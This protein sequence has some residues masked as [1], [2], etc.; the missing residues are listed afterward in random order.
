MIKR[1][2]EAAESQTTNH[3]TRVPKQFFVLAVGLIAGLFWVRLRA[4]LRRIVL[5]R[6][7]LFPRVIGE[8]TPQDLGMAYEEVWFPAR[9]GL[10]L[11]G[12]YIPALPEV[13]PKN[14]T[15]IMGHGHTGNKEPDL[16][17]A[18]FFCNAGYNVFMFDF[19]GHGRSEG[20]R[21][22]SMG[23][24]ERLDVHGAVDWLLGRGQERFAAFGIS[25]GASILVM[26]SA[27]NPY[28]KAVV[29]D[30][31]YAHLYRSIAAEINNMYRLPLWL[32]RPLAHYAWRILASHHS[33]PLDLASPADYVA[34]IAPR[35]L[36]IIH[37]EKDRL[38]RVE[39]A[40]ILYQLAGQPKELWIQ[41]EVAHAQGY[42]TYGP[43]YERRIL[44]F[45]EQ[46]D[47]DSAPDLHAPART[48]DGIAVSGNG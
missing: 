35:P 46:V 47:W 14:V 12:W 34:K 28:I 2:L 40:Y 31:A 41:P 26:A 17:Y 45:L 20:P 23:Y 9:D 6:L 8:R 39:N 10:K 3:R 18:A 16:G 11:H 22:T 25:M 30:S 27:E 33:F 15:V 42:I 4:L 36:L 5:R 43:V 32:A 1:R 19:R 13:A 29:S 24:W 21:G 7:A 44:D 38:T 37:G 48:L